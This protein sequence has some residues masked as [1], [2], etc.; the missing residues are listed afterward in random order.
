MLFRKPAADP[1]N[2]PDSSCRTTFPAESCRQPL[3]TTQA[4]GRDQAP[5]QALSGTSRKRHRT[6][7]ELF[8]SPERDDADL[9]QQPRTSAAASPSQ[10]P[11]SDDETAIIHTGRGPDDG[12]EASSRRNIQHLGLEDDDAANCVWQN[13]DQPFDADD[14]DQQLAQAIALSLKSHAAATGC[15]KDKEPMV[16]WDAVTVAAESPVDNSP[17]LLQFAGSIGDYVWVH[18]RDRPFRFGRVTRAEVSEGQ[19][20][21]DVQVHGMCGEEIFQGHQLCKHYFQGQSVLKL[22]STPPLLCEI[23][24]SRRR[25]HGSMSGGP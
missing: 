3:Q 2:L 14:T 10:G 22:D 16:D 18:E 7:R 4:S 13:V 19:Q 21:Y 11:H 8:Q 6:R 24:A 17:K 23:S 20:Y 5:Q 15:G 25:N 1:S 12:P 9:L